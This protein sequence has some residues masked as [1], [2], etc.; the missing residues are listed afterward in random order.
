MTRS[1]SDLAEALDAL[2]EAGRVALTETPDAMV[3]YQLEGREAKQI[4]TLLAADG[5]LNVRATDEGGD[6]DP[7]TI[8]DDDQR[9][10]VRAQKPGIPPGIEAVLTRS[11]L[12]AALDRAELAARVWIHGLNDPFETL[13]VRFAPWGDNSDFMPDEIPPSP[14]R[15]VRV[16]NDGNQFP[17]DLGRWLLRD[18]AI[19]IEGRGIQP[20]RRMALEQLGHALADEIEPDGRLLFRGPPATRF[21]PN[22]DTFVEASSLEAIERAALWVFE[23]P[24]ELENRHVLLAAEIARAALTGGSPTELAEISGTALEGAKIAYN[25]GVTQQSRDTL[26][27]LADLRKSVGDETARLAESTRALATAVAGS[28]LANLG[29]IVARLSMPATNSWVPAAAV[30]LG[31]VLAIYVGSIIWSGMHY[32]KLQETIRSQW[33]NRLYRFLD[34]AE[35]ERMVTDPV[36]RAERGFSIAALCGGTMSLLLLV[37][38]W[39]IAGAA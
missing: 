16:L 7:T 21:T 10:T 33:R 1:R 13:T 34:E 25:F 4:L 5:W 22:A 2:V 8:G 30:T 39:M 3:A 15:V 23:N 38:V 32:L 35:Y 31:I 17:E 29:I 37:S 27:A 26:K 11:G 24:R 19:T 20:W 18:P 6:L 36:K 12:A 28:V 9:I 14:R